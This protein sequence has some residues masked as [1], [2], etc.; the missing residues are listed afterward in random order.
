MSV[1]F[2]LL[3]ESKCD[4]S[5]DSDVEGLGLEEVGGI[6]VWVVLCLMIFLLVF[7]FGSERKTLIHKS[8]FSLYS[9]FFFF[10]L[11]VS[12][13]VYVSM[14]TCIYYMDGA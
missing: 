11:F 13:F 14:Y 8:A 3:P 4:V 1:C 10:C 9:F 5:D 7:W 2:R 12:I 6:F